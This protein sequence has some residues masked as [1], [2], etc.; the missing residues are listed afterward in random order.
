MMLVKS[1]KTDGIKTEIYQVSHK[2]FQVIQDGEEVC[3]PVTS[4]KDLRFFWGVALIIAGEKAAK[5]R[6]EGKWS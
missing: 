1:E 5:A 6:G 3:S 4:M 2:H